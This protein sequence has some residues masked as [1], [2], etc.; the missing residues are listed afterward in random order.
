MKSWWCIASIFCVLILAALVN[1]GC[2]KSERV[3]DDD[4]EKPPEFKFIKGSCDIVWF[5]Y[6]DSA[7]VNLGGVV[8]SID[9]LDGDGLRDVVVTAGEKSSSEKT[10]IEIRSGKDGKVLKSFSYDGFYY[11]LAQIGDVDGDGTKDIAL[12]GYLPEEDGDDDSVVDDDVIPSPDEPDYQVIVISPQTGE[13][14]WERCCVEGEKEFGAALSGAVDY[15]EDGVPDVIVGS[16]FPSEEELL[17]G[18]VHVVSGPSGETF[19]TYEA[20]QNA[21]ESFGDSV[22]QADDLDGDGK[23]DIY[24]GDPRGPSD[25]YGAGAVFALATQDGSVLWMAKGTVLGDAPDLLG[26][27]IVVVDDLNGDGTRDVI[28]SAHNHA[29]LDIGETTGQV[30]ALNG[31]TGKKLWSTDGR[32]FGEHFGLS[33]ADAGDIDGDGIDDAIVGAPT[34]GI[35]PVLGQSGRFA[36]LSGKDGKILVDVEGIVGEG[37]ESDGLGYAVG[38]V[39]DITG[40]GRDEVIVGAPAAHKNLGMIAVLSCKE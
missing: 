34:P 40:D 13:K 2:V 32:R 12:G 6:G 22:A 1:V 4:G 11:E 5:A 3:G 26:D 16:P 18:K 14:I 24:V 17:P 36:I 21:T 28:A 38:S 23:L 33:I 35:P 20:P 25:Y 10:V 7:K 37:E 27:D 8:D 9:D 29:V 31:L 19:L 30:Q 15:D 39:D